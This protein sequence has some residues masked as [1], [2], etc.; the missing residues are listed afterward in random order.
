MEEG[1]PHPGQILRE[2]FLRPIGWTAEMLADRLSVPPEL[3]R[4]LLDERKAVTPA[5]ALRLAR[6][7]QISA[8]YWMEL[9]ACY[10]LSRTRM[11]DV[12]AIER[13]RPFAGEATAAESRST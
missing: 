3:M 11:S 13:I 2:E 6:L 8:N 9:Q 7:F 12:A 4:D 5:V 10:E 1:A